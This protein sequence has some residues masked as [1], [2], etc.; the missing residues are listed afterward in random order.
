MKYLIVGAGISG[1][2][3]AYAI[4]QKYRTTDMMIIE[5]TNRIGGR[6][7][8]VDFQEDIVDLGAGRIADNQTNMMKLI[9]IFHLENETMQ[10]SMS[11]GYVKFKEILN[12]TINPAI[13]NYQFDSYQLVRDSDF[14]EILDKM[15]KLVEDK[16]YY[17]SAMNQNFYYFLSTLYGKVKADLMRIQ[18]GYDHTFYRQNAITAID[19]FHQAFSKDRVYRTFRD[20]MFE[21]IEKFYL[22]LSHHLIP[23]KYRTK[24][25]EIQKEEGFY[26]CLMEGGEKITCQNVILAIPKKNLL[27]IPFLQPH[28]KIL[29]SVYT[30]SLIKIFLIFP[31]VDGK[32]WFEDIVSILIFDDPIR[33]FIVVDKKKGIAMI[34]ADNYHA[35]Y[36]NNLNQAGI[37]KQNIMLHLRRL[38]SKITIPEPLD[39]YIKFH[40]KGVHSWKPGYSYLDVS[41]KILCLDPKEKIYIVGE[42]YSDTQQWAEGALRTVKN[43]LKILE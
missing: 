20:G 25:M 30:V 8:S 24:I 1:L 43:L 13:I 7:E 11:K 12:T 22:Y 28:L 21:I 40:K 9:E 15:K 19:F 14:Y 42:A 23:I 29:K 10:S 39:I 34:Y 26:H 38:F 32:V 4:H 33:Q 3:T 41:K 2:Y 18:H 35:Q 36:W 17:T 31:L 27:K 6:I 5:K 37:I 16:E